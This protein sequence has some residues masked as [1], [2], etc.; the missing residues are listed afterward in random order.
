MS[1]QSLTPNTAQPLPGEGMTI[2]V[3]S[4]ETA[5]LGH[6]LTPG[7][8]LLQNRYYCPRCGDRI[9]A[10]LEKLAAQRLTCSHV[11]A[12]PQN[13]AARLA[14]YFAAQLV[15]VFPTEDVVSSL[16][17]GRIQHKLLATT[18][19]AQKAAQSKGTD[20]QKFRN[21]I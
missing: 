15:T 18:E 13:G 1:E 12:R 4:R 14:E 20:I 8:A 16:C 10:P 3:L 6:A 5:K 9:T 21:T 2:Y 11:S 7:A 17:R 19:K